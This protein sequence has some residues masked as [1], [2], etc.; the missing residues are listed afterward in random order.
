MNRPRALRLIS[1]L[2]GTATL[3]GLGTGTIVAAAKAGGLGQWVLAIA[4]FAAVTIPIFLFVRTSGAHLNPVV[5]TALAVSGRIAWS[6][7]P[8]YVG[9]QFVGAFVGSL[10]VLAALGDSAHLGATIPLNG[11][12]VRAF[13]AESAFTALLISAVFLLAD[14]G[15]GR[16][17]WRL[18]LPGL[19]VGVSTF[20]IGPWTGCSLNPARTV[21]PAVLTG[22]YQDLWV[23]LIAVP[24]GGWLV[25]IVWKP[26]AVDRL[27]RG[28]G[29]A[30]VTR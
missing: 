6:D 12:L 10:V 14:R 4:W 29:R 17:R 13:V 26:R 19:V 21:A 11:D 30:E 1:E 23:Y 22:L 27:R 9:T 7:V 28:P 8:A 20:L 25:A 16:A 3:V 15:E 18:F 5:T 2:G 24:L